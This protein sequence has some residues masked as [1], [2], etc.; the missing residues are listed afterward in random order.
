VTKPGDWLRGLREELHITRVAVERFTSEAASKA[1]NE[2]YRI[3]RG[4]LTQI[5]QISPRRDVRS[6][7]ADRILSVSGN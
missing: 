5:Y 6:Q 3:R 2:R 7:L 1:D 4:R